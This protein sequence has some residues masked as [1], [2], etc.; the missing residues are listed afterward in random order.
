LE[1][2][3]HQMNAIICDFGLARMN[4][5]RYVNFLFLFSFSDY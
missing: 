4:S 2:E 1:I 3:N 5:E